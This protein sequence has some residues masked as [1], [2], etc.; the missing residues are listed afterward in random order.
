MD[1]QEAAKELVAR[2]E[3]PPAPRD[4]W[5][6]NA[7]M[8]LVT[9]VVVGHGWTL[10]PRTTTVD[11]IYDFLYFW[12]VPAF[13]LITG[14]LSRSF[15]YTRPR[16]WNLIRTV[17]VP[18][19]LFELLLGWFRIYVGG[20]TL[21]LLWINPHWPM[22]YLSALFF[23]RL[24]TPGLKRMRWSIAAAVVISIITGARGIEV[25][26]IAR[27]LGLL[28]FFVMGLRMRPEHFV[29]L[30]TR[31]ARIW[32]VITLVVLFGIARANDWLWSTEWLYYRSNYSDLES[33][34]AQ[35]M[36]IRACLLLIGTL[37]AFAF[38]TLIPARR[39]WFTSLGAATLVV[40]LCHGFFIKGAAYAGLPAWADYHPWWGLI[41]VTPACVALA[42]WLARPWS[43]RWLGYLVDPIGA[44]K[45][46]RLRL[47]TD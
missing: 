29:A 28:P 12:H 19:L 7:K 9:L 40:Y 43:A 30:R 31:T 8:V 22:W 24:L 39:T 4:P 3:P 25:F 46:L 10:L 44:I 42:I 38:F 33:S 13:V 21:R 45:E 41:L 1:E 11:W 20:E 14:Y 32:G 27:V 23:W 35:A 36:L 26:D 17:L 15:E 5:F 37:G 47:R 6:D 34:E 18:Y 2:V 16:V